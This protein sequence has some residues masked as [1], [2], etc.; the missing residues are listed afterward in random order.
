MKGTI[1]LYQASYPIT[2]HLNDPTDDALVAATFPPSAFD[3]LDQGRDAL[4]WI[5]NTAN[6]SPIAIPV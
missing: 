2:L 1:T 6:D 4:L 3:F 5:D